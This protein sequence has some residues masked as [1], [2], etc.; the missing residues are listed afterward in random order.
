M[1][2]DDIIRLAEVEHN[3]WNVERLIF[4]FRAT[5]KEENKEICNDRTA[6]NKYKKEQLA[7]FDIRPY[8]NLKEDEKKI[9]ADEYDIC[10]SECLPKI[11]N[12]QS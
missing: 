8:N 5:T 2:K 3:R 7:H 11:I 1:S 6:K 4:G 12:E 10:L 9:K